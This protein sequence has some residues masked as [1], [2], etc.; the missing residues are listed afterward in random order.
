M[1]PNEHMLIFRRT[2]FFRFLSSG[3]LTHVDGDGDAAAAAAD[4]IFRIFFFAVVHINS[5]C[6]CWSGLCR[7]SPLFNDIAVA[8]NVLNVVLLDGIF[9]KLK[10]A[11]LADSIRTHK[12]HINLSRLTRDTLREF[13]FFFF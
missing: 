9:N 6:F 5:S 13:V 11:L 4:V 12:I 2:F 8:A 7:R 10:I 3:V 1:M